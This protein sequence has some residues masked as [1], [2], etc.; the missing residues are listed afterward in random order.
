MK[1]RI[2]VNIDDFLH[3]EG[4]LI[5]PKEFN[6]IVLPDDIIKWYKNHWIERTKE[7]NDVRS[8]R[9]NTRIPN[10]EIKAAIKRLGYTND[11]IERHYIAIALALQLATWKLDIATELEPHLKWDFVK[12]YGISRQ[13]F[14]QWKKTMPPEP[15]ASDILK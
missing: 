7:G 14:N 5:K 11:E 8:I 12:D 9:W 13:K 15:H 2:D 4:K 6:R 1:K 10:S 3:Y